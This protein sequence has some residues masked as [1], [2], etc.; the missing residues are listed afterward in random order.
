MQLYS[1]CMSAA[2]FVCSFY[3]LA[4]YSVLK[5]SVGLMCTFQQECEKVG[6]FIYGL[7][8]WGV[9]LKLSFVLLPPVFICHHAYASF[10]IQSISL[11]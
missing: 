3:A 2:S 1:I 10:I 11:Q 6:M 4:V 8:W 7:E 5:N 9:Q